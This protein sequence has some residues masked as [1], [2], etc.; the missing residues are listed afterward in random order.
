MSHHRSPKGASANRSVTD[1]RRVNVDFRRGQLRPTGLYCQVMSW[2]R[3]LWAERLVPESLRAPVDPVPPEPVASRTRNDWIVDIIGFLFALSFAVLIVMSMLYDEAAKPVST[4]Q[5]V[6]ETVGGALACLSL[7]WRRRW[8][9]GVALACVLLCALSATATIA[10]LLALF[11]LAVHRTARPVVFVAALFV[12]SAGA[13]ALYRPQTEALWLVV[14]LAAVS[15]LAAT[16]WG[17]FVRA[18]RQLVLTLR[19]RALRA[20]TDQ[21][22]HAD[23]A[24]MAERTR[25]AREM[26]DVLAHRISLVALHAGGLEVRPDLPPE[27]VRETAVLLRSTARQALEE[28]RG[29]IGILRE[30]P[31]QEPTPEAPQPKLADIPRLIEETRRAG[32]KI[33]FEMRVDDAHTAPIGLGRDAYRIVQEALTN[34]GKH[35]R[36]TAALVR[37]S[38]APENGLHVNIRNRLPV[39]AHAGPA[40]PGSGA[41]LLGL[42]ERVTLAGGMLVLGPDGSGD[43]VVDAELRWPA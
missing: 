30:E 40:L 43:F 5:L 25:I 24:R 16:A 11:S 38:G 17:M 10:G 28:L 13:Y 19:E 14:L 35:A 7:W 3:T 41:G 21:R 31:G 33:D 1:F 15:S 4:P 36:G 34:I 8:P 42:Q 18:R 32:A 20:E 27:K 6:V 39:R 2:P 9:V 37:V 22:L 23:Q 26:H 29:V 12:L